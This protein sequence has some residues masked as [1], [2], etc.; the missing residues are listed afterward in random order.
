MNTLSI[1]Y[2]KLVRLK[3]NKSLS[4][5]LRIIFSGFMLNSCTEK[6][7]IPLDSSYIRLVVEGAITTDTMPHTV[8]I[9][10]TASYYLNEP[11]PVVRGAS[12]TIS[13]G[14]DIFPLS[15]IL[16]GV[17]ETDASVFGLPG[18]TYSLSIKLAEAIGG[19][20]DYSARAY[21]NKVAS[22]DSVGLRYNPDWGRSGVW[23][24]KCYVLEPPTIDYYRFMIYRNNYLVTDSINKWFVTDDKFFNGNY[25][26]GATVAYL[27]QGNPGEGLRVGDIVTVEVDNISKDYFDFIMQVQAEVR[28]SNPLFSGPPANVK[29][30]I[31]HGAVGFFTAYD[32]TRKGAVTPNFSGGKAFKQQGNIMETR[33]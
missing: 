27:N 23:E 13:D 11:A 28:G 30:N 31:D 19:Y 18:H 4:F 16:P 12:V 10:T 8:K 25:T 6:I 15:E 14:P 29:G 33:K 1:N 2:L 20:T 5:L 24:V 26:N 3:E 17:Y 9:T 32:L 7:D 22:L 21:L